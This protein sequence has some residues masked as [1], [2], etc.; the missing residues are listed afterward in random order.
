MSAFCGTR[1]SPRMS[2]DNAGN[3]VCHGAVIARSGKQTYRAAELGLGTNDLIE[4][5]RSPR[6]VLSKATIASAHGKLVCDGHPPQFVAPWNS[7]AYGKGMV[8]YP[9]EGPE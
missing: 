8:L 7:G 2:R 5:Y 6:E 9:R 1:I 3:L 4:V